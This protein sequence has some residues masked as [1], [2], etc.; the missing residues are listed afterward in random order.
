[1]NLPFSIDHTYKNYIGGSQ[2]RPDAHYSRPV[3]NSKEEIV[4]VVPESNR[5]DLRDAVE[6]AKK[7]SPG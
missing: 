6:A 5:K 4:G 7:A 3:K 1:M 2:K